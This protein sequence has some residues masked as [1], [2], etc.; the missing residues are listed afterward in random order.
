MLV[1]YV[2]FSKTKRKRK[3]L[4]YKKTSYMPE[5]NLNKLFNGIFINAAKYQNFANIRKSIQVF[6]GRLSIP[7]DFWFQLQL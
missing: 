5:E 2:E 4:A 1:T 6:I 7:Q 3:K